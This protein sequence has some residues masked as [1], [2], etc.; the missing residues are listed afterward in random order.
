MG[1]HAHE[2]SWGRGGVGVG[3]ILLYPSLPSRYMH[4]CATRK[5]AS[6]KSTPTRR[7]AI[8]SHCMYVSM[9]ALDST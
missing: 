6:T 3:A 2:I 5:S 8:G 4:R 9:K 1:E 7:H